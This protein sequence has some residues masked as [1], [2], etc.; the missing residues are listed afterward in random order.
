MTSR[1]RTL[2]AAALALTLCPAIVQAQLRREE[3]VAVRQFQG[4]HAPMGDL[5]GGLHRYPVDQGCRGVRLR[6]LVLRPS[7]RDRDF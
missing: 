3:R 7:V 2:L 1:R 6:R 4:C 5:S